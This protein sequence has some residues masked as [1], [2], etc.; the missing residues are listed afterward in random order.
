MRSF[1]ITCAVIA[2]SVLVVLIQT[3][4]IETFALSAFVTQKP[5]IVR[6]FNAFVPYGDRLEMWE[7]SYFAIAPQAY[8]FAG[9][10]YKFKRL[11]DV[12]LLLA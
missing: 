1:A 2:T 11:S 5:Q 9:V 12:I 7:L 10:V 4:A 6:F 8:A 3:R